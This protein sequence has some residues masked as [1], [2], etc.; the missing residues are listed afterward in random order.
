MAYVSYRDYNEDNVK[1]HV[2]EKGGVYIISVKLKNGGYKVVYVGQSVDLKKRL[3]E[4]LRESEPNE[5]LRTN[6][7]KYYTVYKWIEIPTSNGRDNEEKYQ[8]N[9]LNPTCNIKRPSA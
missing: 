2:P 4:H 3:L 1:T 8:I 6:V 7:D 5:C 9:E